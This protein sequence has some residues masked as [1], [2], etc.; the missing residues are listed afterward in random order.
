MYCALGFALYVTPL[1]A[2]VVMSITGAEVPG[3]RV[4]TESPLATSYEG[5]HIK[6]EASIDYLLISYLQPAPQATTVTGHVTYSWRDAT[7]NTE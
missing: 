7:V 3:K 5:Y 2:V 6:C 4:L 1:S